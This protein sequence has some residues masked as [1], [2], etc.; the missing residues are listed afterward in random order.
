MCYH[1]IKFI[2]SKLDPQ[3]PLSFYISPALVKEYMT[4]DDF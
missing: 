4:K 1:H 3:K 2:V